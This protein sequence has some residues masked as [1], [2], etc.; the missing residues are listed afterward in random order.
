MQAVV[1]LVLL[2]H[3]LLHGAHFRERK[4]GVSDFGH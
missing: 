4:H 1:A 3:V 2:L